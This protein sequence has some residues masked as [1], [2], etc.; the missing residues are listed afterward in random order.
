MHQSEFIRMWGTNCWTDVFSYGSSIINVW[1]GSNDS[2]RSFPVHKNLFASRSEFFKRAIKEPWTKPGEATICLPDDNPE[3]FKLYMILTYSDQVASKRERL[4]YINE[5]TSLTQLYVLAEKL[6]DRKAKNLIIDAM[7]EFLRN[8][9][10]KGF[11]GYQS[12]EQWSQVTLPYESLIDLYE[13]TP[14]GSPAR[15]LLVH[16]HANRYCA[17]Y[18]T[19]GRDKLPKDFIYELAVHLIKVAPPT[20]SPEHQPVLPL[21]S[22]EFHEPLAGTEKTLDVGMFGAK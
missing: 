3:T 6:Q 4:F 7:H 18:L 21:P 17:S 1:V 19:A 16:F 14:E 10:P 11:G 22:S 9:L 15:K 8:T 20:G 5:W 13:G 2:K 12:Q